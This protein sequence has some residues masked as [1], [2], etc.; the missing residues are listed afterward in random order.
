[1]IKVT[2]EASFQPGQPSQL[3]RHQDVSMAIVK[4]CRPRCPRMRPTAP[5]AW[6]PPWNP[7]SSTLRGA[8]GPVGPPGPCSGTRLQSVPTGGSRE[9]LGS[10]LQGPA[11][12]TLQSVRRSGT[13]PYTSQVARP[14]G[15]SD[16]TLRLGSGSCPRGRV[17]EAVTSSWWVCTPGEVGVRMG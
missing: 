10:A 12:H 13:C 6:P 16:P 15:A 7:R 4:I 2:Y 9:L 14:A 17:L 1:M 8:P 5:A 11:C 3:L